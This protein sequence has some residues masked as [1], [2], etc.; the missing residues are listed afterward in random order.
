M[1]IIGIA[2]TIFQDSRMFLE[3]DLW[4]IRKVRDEGIHQRA[5]N[6][7]DLRW[8]KCFEGGDRQSEALKLYAN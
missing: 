4:Q 5:H 8:L 3:A 2:L 6:A 1:F 7:T